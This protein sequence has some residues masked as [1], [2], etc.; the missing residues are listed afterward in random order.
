[1]RIAP[2]CLVFAPVLLLAVTA[3]GPVQVANGADGPTDQAGAAQNPPSTTIRLRVRV[4]DRSGKPLSKAKGVL[5]KMTPPRPQGR[6]ADSEPVITKAGTAAPSGS[7][8]YVETQALPVKSG[9]VLEIQADGFAPELTRWTH[10]QQSGTVELPPVQLKRLGTIAGTIVDRQGQG[11]PNVTVIQAGDGAK[12]LEAVTDPKGNFRLGD[13]PEGRT[14]VCFEAAGFRFHGTTLTA[15][16]DGARI[17]LER[18]GEANPRVL[19]LAPAAQPWSNE[20]RTAL[21]KKLLDP[22]IARVL[23]E[24]LIAEQDRPILAIAARLDP[25]RILAQLDRLK[26]AVPNMAYGVRY[27]IGYGLLERGKPEA[28]LEAIDKF[29]DAQSKL[30]AY[31]YWFEANPAKTKYP[32]AHRLAL[33]KARAI[34]DT[35]PA[36]AQRPV[37]LCDLGAQLWDL[38]DH[39][40]ARKIFQ[41]CQTRLD[42]LPA[43]D[44]NNRDWLRIQLAIA[45]SRDDVAR[46]KKLAA[47][48]EPD[49]M[50]R[51]AAEIA[52]HH[53]RDVEPFLADVP[54]DLSLMQLRGLA[55]SF[56]A[57][58]WRVSRQDPAAAE[59]L[60]LKYVQVPQP[61]TDAEKMFGLGGSFGL[62]LS[63]EFIEFQV[64]K[65][66]A[67][68][69]G[70]IAD[71]AAAHDPAG[72]RQALG[73]SI[74]LVRPLRT[75][76]L[77]PTTQNY[78][79]PAVLM[80]MLVPAAERID[81]ALAREVLWR[82]LSLRVAMSGESR[83][84]EMHDIDTCLLA[85]LVRFYDRPLAEMLLDPVLART[86]SAT[87]GGM[88]YYFWVVRS[89]VLESPHRALAWADTLCDLPSW[90]GLGARD[91]ARRVIANVL[92]GG[93]NWDS[94]PSQ[95]LQ[96][97]LGNIQSVYG[98]YVDRD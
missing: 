97:E 64:I 77:Y 79:G 9:Y 90:I 26:F 28:A 92:S 94:D 80:A 19:K 39:D 11:I 6:S 1:M 10:P 17:E 65:L 23:A 66:K 50:I 36:A 86:R 25:E 82:A 13:V 84:R 21:V 4:E 83:E 24:P 63:K 44:N 7:D 14:I 62:N 74:E 35:L 72:A 54:G 69:Y 95:R 43:A 20:Q 12:R 67:A 22:L 87:F 85:N 42:K 29:K 48:V 52:R 56:P 33:A 41:E 16:S 71:G 46:A 45:V 27:S 37:Q 18:T 93:A 38:G 70:L 53:P 81:P 31:L 61:K 2:N 91:S 88:G 68:C 30:Q 60:L 73:K 57:L 15:P 5:F 59:R 55:N 49:S 89:L 3:T 78:H 32:D 34:L 47:D 8:G 75:G 40:G 58:C 51:L 76:H 98:F 96:S